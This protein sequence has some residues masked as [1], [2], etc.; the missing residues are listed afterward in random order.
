LSDLG[1]QS[2]KLIIEQIEG[3]EVSPIINLPTE[4]VV[5]QSC[6]C[7][8][9][10]DPLLSIS[11]FEYVSEIKGI[12]GMEA[13]KDEIATV[14]LETIDIPENG[15]Q[16]IT[17]TLDS[18]L[19]VFTDNTSDE[20]LRKLIQTADTYPDIIDQLQ[21]MITVIRSY[22]LQSIPDSETRFLAENIHHQARMFLADIAQRLQARLRLDTEAE[23]NSLRIF[24]E[25]LSRITNRKNLF[26]L[27]T[28][29]L[30]NQGIPGC[31]LVLSD[32]LQPIANHQQLIFAFNSEERYAIPEDGLY[33]EPGELPP[34]EYFPHEHQFSFVS[35][36]L[37]IYNQENGYVLFEADSPNGALYYGLA[38]QISSAIGTIALI[39]QVDN[40][41]RQLS[42]AAEISRAASSILD[43]KELIAKAVDLIKEHFELYYV[44]LFLVDE[45]R[46]WAELRA[47]TGEAGAQ[48]LAENWRLAVGGDSMIGHC[49]TTNEADIQL[50]VDKAPIHLRNPHL[51][52]TKSEMALPLTSRGSVMGAL[53]IQSTAANAFS[54]EDVSVLQTM[55]DQIATSIA[56]AQLFE[57][58]QTALLDTETLLNI[59]RLAGA[60]IE[61][62]S[63]TKQALD[64]TLKST[65]I[66]AGLFSL[67]NPQTGQLE[68]TA[69]QVPEALLT[70]LQANGLDGTLCDWV[71]KHR[72]T[73]IVHNLAENSPIDA[74]G[75]IELGFNSYQGVPL[76]T[77]G[78]IFG[79]LCTFSEAILR[80]DDSNISLLQAIGQ[81]VAVAIQNTLL[82][83]QTQKAL[84]E[85]EKQSLRL[86]ALNEL[87]KE[88]GQAETLDEIYQISVSAL[89][90]VVQADHAGLSIVV[91]DGMQ[92]EFMAISNE[93]N[94]T[95]IAN[96]FSLADSNIGEVIRTKRPKITKNISKVT[97]QELGFAGTRLESLLIVPLIV[98]GEAIGAFSFES[99]NPDYF[100]EIDL[101]LGVQ[102]A[103]LI[104][105]AIENQ[106]LIQQSQAALAELEAT[107]RRYQIQAWSSYNQS[108]T[109]SGYQQTPLGVEPIGRRATPETQKALEEQNPLISED[110]DNLRLT[111]PI[112]LRDQPIGAIGLQAQE[113]KR[114]WGP[115][116]I[117]LAQELGEQFALA[118][119]S[120][121]LL[122]ETQR[123]A[124]RE[125]LVAE[126]TTKIRASNDPQ[127]MLQTAAQELKNALKSKRTQVLLKGNTKND[128]G[129]AKG[130]E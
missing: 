79:T 48:M 45:R 115:D 104:G 57:R 91:G 50:D 5:R 39:E 7:I 125:R 40:R 130:G 33:L 120:L 10:E 106:N 22:S 68:I 107:Q 6:G 100:S 124:A 47:G 15:K 53:T 4:M 94:G 69:H 89:S 88:L 71:Y 97:L 20:F 129:H 128:N 92:A 16:L 117:A 109:A 118:A 3:K 8:Q 114:K 75:L 87:S 85:T 27:L 64:L 23:A 99:K 76:E 30:P 24:N 61:F 116:E 90:N 62:E 126:I 108:R 67:F 51:P 9:S 70:P 113:G 77:K 46:Q 36:A 42:A 11:N 111:I 86:A 56:N 101:D 17:E 26:D 44:G 28:E 18:Y 78:Q 35:E 2:V 31:L 122:D 37:N 110:G 123:R 58:T 60:S 38:D 41:A 73:L 29:Y 119:E 93:D 54:Q 74:T 127:T 83:E 1:R 84:A 63:Y 103:S 102:L 12:S 25:Q 82:F 95:G 65:G 14:I 52:N 32:Q 81:Q 112:M 21:T 98:S 19:S 72:E 49:I 121:R 43:P 80:S 34:A 59:S 105:N 55:S 96:K 13:A 66:E